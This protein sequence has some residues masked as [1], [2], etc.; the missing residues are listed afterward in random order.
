MRSLVLALILLAASCGAPDESPPPRTDSGNV[1][2]DG[3]GTQKPNPP[4]LDPVPSTLCGPTA[5]IRGTAK[6][7]ATVFAMGGLET[8]GVTKDT[9]PSTGRFCMDVRLKMGASNVIEVRVHDPVLGDS[10]PAVITV[11]QSDCKD[12]DPDP[13][14]TPKPT[15]V[16]LGLKGHASKTADEGNE[17]FL[18]DGNATTAVTYSGYRTPFTCCANIWVTMKL[19]KLTEVS[20]IV[21]KWLDG[22]SN[23]AD[24]YKVLVSA[25]SD[26]GDPNLDNG[27]WT[28]VKSYDGSG[29]GG[30]ETV[31][32]SSTKPPAQHV[33]LWLNHQQGF[34]HMAETFTIAELEV[35]DSPKST[36]PNPTT[37]TNTCASLGD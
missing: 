3:G 12:P 5:P 14:P 13:T 36:G 29:A 33:A 32:L 28:I 23:Y 9:N 11:Q 16:A 10:D 37:P 1:R 4:I 27:Y 17:G 15:N 19:A 20:K 25:V 31:D 30:T 8:S 2:T 7:G 24:D 22:T 26:P 18:T 21:V 34:W 35:W 6:P